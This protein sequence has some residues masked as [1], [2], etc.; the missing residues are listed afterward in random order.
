[1]SLKIK[2]ISGVK[3]TTISTVV[4]AILQLLQLSI[5]TRFLNPSD[6]GSMALVMVVIGFSQAFLDMG[7]SNAIIYNFGDVLDPNGE[8]AVGSG[9]AKYYSPL[10]ASSL[11][12]AGQPGGIRLIWGYTDSTNTTL[13]AFPND[14]IGNY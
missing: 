13:R 10:G 1:M 12:M 9:G 7:I 4:V 8:Y 6:F 5:L 3:W 2:A 14:G 11:E